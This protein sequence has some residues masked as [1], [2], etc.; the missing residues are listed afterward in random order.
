MKC[1]RVIGERHRYWNIKGLGHFVV[2]FGLNYLRFIRFG[3]Y[4]F[5]Q[6]VVSLRY[7]S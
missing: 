3:W 2:F 4:H 6:I 7:H 1:R 5:E